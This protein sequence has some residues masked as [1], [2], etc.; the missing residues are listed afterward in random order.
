MGVV[1]FKLLG[2]FS[3]LSDICA[4][5]CFSIE[6]CIDDFDLYSDLRAESGRE[7]TFDAFE[8]SP[9]RTLLMP[10]VGLDRILLLPEA[11]LEN[12]LPFDA[13][14]AGLEETLLPFL[15]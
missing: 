5:P 9:D 14:E 12:T 8:A 15:L 4:L 1:L 6:F 3:F 11:G 13:P 10:D 2:C 7:R